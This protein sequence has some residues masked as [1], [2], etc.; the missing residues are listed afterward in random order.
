[1]IMKKTNKRPD[2]KKMVVRILCL[3]LATLFV[4]V[5]ILTAWPSLVGAQAYSYTSDRLIRVGL[6]FGASAVSSVALTSQSGFD[7]G[8]F[9][10]ESRVF[11]SVASSDSTA[12]VASCAENGTITITT[13]EWTAVYS[14]TAAGSPVCVRARGD[15]AEIGVGANTYTGFA[16]L[17]FIGGAMR[18]VSVVYLEDYIRGVVASEVYNSWPAEALK[19]QAVV[20]RSFTLYN[21]TKHRSDGFDICDKPHCQAYTGVGKC[22]E[23][24][25]AAV[26]DTRGII[27]AYEGKPA[28]T[29]YHSS[30]GDTTES[31]SSAWGS[32]PEAYPYLASVNVGFN[33]T[34]D[35]VNGR[36]SYTVSAS[37]LTDYINSKEEYAGILK[38]DVQTIECE[39]K[40]GSDYV[41]KLTVSDAFDNE[42]V[43]EKSTHVRN[44]IT[45]YCKSAC[46]TISSHTTVK[47]AD[48]KDLILDSGNMYVIS[49]QGE[50]TLS[51][52]STDIEVLTSSGLKTIPHTGE[53]VFTIAGEGYG[54]GV[55]LS[56]YGAMTLAER[57]YDYRYILGLYYP[58]TEIVDYTTLA[59]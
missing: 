31:A 38:G 27:V 25:D 5:T 23:A 11:T 56:Q 13:P 2:S 30:S 40:D 17:T 43:V 54:H 47:A 51:A 48:Q 32:V 37:E 57:G 8:T 49:A 42:I 10:G 26:R 39:R 45:K 50:Q 33:E 55:G 46:F 20:A 53:R 12:L 58:G 22:V 18:V 4:L 36:W 59:G 52:T 21:G 6:N 1:M 9:D 28:L 16:E 19:S 35:Y 3:A 29:T 15:N 7:I 14:H 24:T 34:E 44:F 41:Y